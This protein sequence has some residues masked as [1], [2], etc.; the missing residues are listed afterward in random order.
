M[1][2]NSR[3]HYISIMKA[4]KSIASSCDR[5]IKTSYQVEFEVAPSVDAVLAYDVC[6]DQ[7]M[8]YEKEVSD[9]H[10]CQLAGE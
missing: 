3:V 10:P 5:V 1:E 4:F 2:H 8:D 6:I 7:S 9:C